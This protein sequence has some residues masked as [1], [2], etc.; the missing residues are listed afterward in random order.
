MQPGIEPRRRVVREGDTIQSIAEEFGLS[1]RTVLL[2]NMGTLADDPTRIRPGIRLLIP[3]EDGVLYRWGEGDSLTAVASFYGVQRADIVEYKANR[4]NASTF[5]PTGPTEIPIGTLLF[6]PGADRPLIDWSAVGRPE[7]D[8]HLWYPMLPPR[9][10]DF[11]AE[12]PE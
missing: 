2:S 1:P 4:L 7:G 9:C 8:C 5:T 3:P 6:I 11:G 12:P 10:M